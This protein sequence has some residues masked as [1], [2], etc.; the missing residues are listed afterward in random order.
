M[1]A[2]TGRGEELD[3][4]V[5]GCRLHGQRFGSRAA[6]LVFGLH[7]LSGTMRT[8]D[9][10]GEQIGDVAALVALDLRGRGRSE[11]TPAGTYGWEQHA[12]DVMAVADVLGAKTFA[13]VGHS[14]G[15]SVAMKIAELDAARLRAVV[16]VDVAGRVDP[17]VGPVIAA[18]IER[19]DRVHASEDAYL[20]AVRAEGLFDPWDDHWE[21]VH[22]A[23]LRAVDGGVRSRA[24]PVALD[25][26]R[27][28]TS[29]QDP[30]RRWMHLTMPTLL[31][32]ATQELPGAAGHVVPAAE[33]D[34]FV[35]AVPH[36]SLVEVDANHLTITAHPEAVAAMCDFLRSTCVAAR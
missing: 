34:R 31:V 29:T 24:H 1:D 6:P 19:L 22:L 12:R 17:G 10:L 9:P 15:A 27:A 35:A 25:E 11:A 3:V 20:D 21:R 28:Y 36:A 18:V 30:H 7:G 26:D 33:R 5:N 2:S 32:R 16:L 4:T 23:D 8:F 14:M 13:V